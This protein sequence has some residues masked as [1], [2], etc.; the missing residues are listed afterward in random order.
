MSRPPHFHL[1]HNGGRT[2]PRRAAGRNA[3]KKLRRKQATTRNRNRSIKRPASRRPGNLPPFQPRACRTANRDSVRNAGGRGRS[4]ERD[5]PRCGNEPAEQVDPPRL[6]RSGR[7]RRCG[8]DSR[9]ARRQAGPAFS[10]ARKSVRPSKRSIED[11]NLAPAWLDKGV[12]NARAKAVNCP[13]Q[14]RGCRWAR[15][16]RLQDAEFV[17]DRSP[18]RSPRPS[19]SS[20]RPYSPMRATCRP[21][22]SPTLA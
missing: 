7:S 18:R 22:V 15:F 20:P 2:D 14:G 10:P 21:A 13:P 4:H 6:P 11:R 3:P 1:G 5:C 17:R 12:E 16:P 8:K 9:S 19:S